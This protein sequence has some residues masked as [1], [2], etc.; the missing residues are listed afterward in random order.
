MG[1]SCIT[2]NRYVVLVFVVVPFLATL[3]AIWLFWQ[4][5]VHWSD[6][7]LLVSGYT[8]VILGVGMGFHRMLTHSSFRPHPIVK[9]LLLLLGSMALEGPALEWAATHLKHHAHADQEG[10]FFDNKQE[11]L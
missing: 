7:I 3:F 1:S 8:L 10:L 6:L 5:A 9:V 4:R 2:A 11:Y